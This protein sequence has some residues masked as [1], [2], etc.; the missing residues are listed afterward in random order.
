MGEI[1]AFLV[2]LAAVFLLGNIWFHMVES[3]LRRVKGLFRRR[4]DPP[5]WHPLPP[6]QEENDDV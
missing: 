6:E 1:G 5:A 3:V 2:V 4:K